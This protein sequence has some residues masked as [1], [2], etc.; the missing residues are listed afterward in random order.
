[1]CASKI[2]GANYCRASLPFPGQSTHWCPPPLSQPPVLASLV[3]PG[4]GC[5][6]GRPVCVHAPASPTPKEAQ[7]RAVLGSQYAWS[8]VISLRP[9]HIHP[10]PVRHWLHFPTPRIA[11][12]LSCCALPHPAPDVLACP[13]GTLLHLC[14]MAHL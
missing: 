4:L 12:F 7:I 3:L 13:Q 5:I 6:M 9:Q 14:F 2:A 10:V 11:P 1:M 8:G